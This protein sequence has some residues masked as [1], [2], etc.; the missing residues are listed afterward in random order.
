MARA[1]LVLVVYSQFRRDKEGR[2]MATASSNRG[3]VVLGLLCSCL[4]TAAFAGVSTPN[5]TITVKQGATADLRCTYTSDFTKSRVEWKFVNNQLE[6]FFV[7]YDGTLTASYV[8]RATSVPQGIILNQITSKDA[9]EY[10]CEVTSVDSNG[11]TL[12][13]EAKIQL[14]VIVAPSQPMAHVPNT[15]RTGSAVELRCVETQG[16]PPPTFTWYQ[17]KAPMPPN[18]QNATYTID[19]NTGVLK[20]RAVAA[21]DSGDYYCKAA[22]NEGEQ[23]SAIVRMNVR[24]YPPPPPRYYSVAPAGF[25]IVP[26]CAMSVFYL[27][28]A[29]DVNVGG[30]VAAVVIVLLILA[31][32]GF[33]LWYAYSRGYLDSEYPRHFSVA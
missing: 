21:S 17:N 23:V 8:N 7:Y 6:T 3:A 20:F 11:Q 26:H 32:I 1:G 25:L 22:N 15:V 5:P 27:P 33:G 16:Y 13:G 24:K 19:P 9:G 30:I 12:Y 14:L 18:P 29:E 4:W 2:V 31:L 10:S 28:F